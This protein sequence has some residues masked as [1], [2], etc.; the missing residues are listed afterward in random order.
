MPTNSNQK[1]SI[2]TKFLN[3]LKSLTNKL[4]HPTL[5]FFLISLPLPIITSFLSLF[6]LSLKHPPNPQTIHSKT[7]LTHH[8][9][10]II[11]NHP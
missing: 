1:P 3:N 11:I 9:F 4:P 8:P 6:N 10:P 2:L 5:L 7:I